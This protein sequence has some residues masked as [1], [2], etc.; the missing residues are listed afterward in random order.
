[1]GSV[2]RTANLAL[3]TGL[4]VKAMTRGA[5]ATLGTSSLGSLKACPTLLAV[6]MVMVGPTP[7]PSL[8]EKLAWALFGQ[9][10]AWK[11]LA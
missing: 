8:R 4:P 9:A 6:E 10:S 3:N 5:L 7:F 2:H 11:T 1:L